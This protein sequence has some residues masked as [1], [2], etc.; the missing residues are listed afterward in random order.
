MRQSPPATA[1]ASAAAW[2]K[3]L[4]VCTLLSLLGLAGGMFTCRRLA[5]ALHEPL[6]T[7]ALTTTAVVLA[8]AALAVRVLGRDYIRSADSSRPSLAVL[9]LFGPTAVIAA[10]AFALSLPGTSVAGLTLLWGLLATAE[11]AALIFAALRHSPWKK[12]LSH[13]W[14][15]LLA[16]SAGR[17]RSFTSPTAAPTAAQTPPQPTTALPQPA[18]VLHAGLD[19]VLD[20]VLESPTFD[21]T[22]HDQVTQQVVRLQEPDGT[23]TISGWLRASFLPGQRTTRVHLAFCPPF[24]SVPAVEVEQ[25]DGPPARIKTVQLLPYG[26]RFDL[27]LS[28]DAEESLTVLLQFSAHA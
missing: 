13:A 23:E 21:K 11:F 12:L 27:K 4:A 24:A 1:Q 3:L 18:A 9:I 6:G 19:A 14:L 7:W 22:P 5:G 15:P 2:G 17:L 20:P 25:T 10:A 16:R 8:I 26:V 28:D